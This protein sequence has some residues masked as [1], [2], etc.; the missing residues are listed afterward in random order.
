MSFAEVQ[1]P[2]DISYGS[3]G[4]PEYATDVVNHRGKAVMK[5]AM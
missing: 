4:G 3:R 2:S 1:F 5:N